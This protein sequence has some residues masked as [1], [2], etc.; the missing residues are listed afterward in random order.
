MLR[1]EIDKNISNY[2]SWQRN[3][4]SLGLLK[5]PAHAVYGWGTE[6]ETSWV[7]SI[8]TELFLPLTLTAF[9]CMMLVH[10]SVWSALDFTFKRR[11][12]AGLRFARVS[13]YCKLS[14]SLSP[15][16]FSDCVLI[17]QY[18]MSLL[19]RDIREKYRG[20]SWGPVQTFDL[21]LS[22]EWLCSRDYILHRNKEEE[23]LF[24]V[25]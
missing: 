25:K 15:A 12:D 16:V 9:L 14:D 24:S 13:L 2:C 6:V 3:S 4:V 18:W 23:G 1:S 5:L 20:G 17:S 22:L 21:L 10:C 8:G 19:S 7:V 11:F